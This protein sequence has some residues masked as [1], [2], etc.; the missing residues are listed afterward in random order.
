MSMYYSIHIQVNLTF[1]ACALYK[2]YQK[3]KSKFDDKEECRYEVARYDHLYICCLL[4]NI[5]VKE[6]T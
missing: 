5:T 6:V 2:V 1:L 3:R 4:L